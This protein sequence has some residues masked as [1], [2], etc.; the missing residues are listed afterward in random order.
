M[1][2]TAARQIVSTGHP[3]DA[4]RVAERLYQ[5]GAPRQGHG[6]A[7]GGFHVLVL[8]AEEIQPPAHRFPGLTVVHAGIDDDR[9]SDAEG[10]TVTEAALHVARFWRDGARVLVTCAQGRNRSGLVMA[11]ALHE[12]AGMSGVHA[13]LR[14]RQVRDNALTNDAFVAALKRLPARVGPDMV[15]L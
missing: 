4:S 9:L 15:R 8:C 1:S 3:L 11:L 10:R 5:G 6:L 2:A 12:L 14:V 7:L 13:I